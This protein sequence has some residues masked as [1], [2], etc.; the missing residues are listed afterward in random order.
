MYHPL[1][2]NLIERVTTTTGGGE[3][4][5]PSR[6]TDET[7]SAGRPQFLA[8]VSTGDFDPSVGNADGNPEIFLWELLTGKFHQLTNTAAPVVNSDPYPSDSGR[9][10][11]FSSSGDL[12]NNDGSDSGNPGMGLSNP[13][14][15]QEVF[16]YSINTSQ[17]FPFDGDF[18]QVSNGPA[19]TVSAKPVIGGYWFPRQCQSTAYTSDFDQLGNG[20]TGTHIYVYNRPGG[21][22]EQMDAPEIP[23]GLSPGNYFD[24]NISS[25]SNFARGPFVVFDTDSDLWMNQS[26]GRNLFRFRVFHPRMTQ[27]TDQDAGDVRAP[28]TSDGGKWIALESEVSYSTPPR[29]SS[30]G[31][32]RRSTRTATGKSFV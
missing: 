13:D 1:A 11:V 25:A 20:A 26:T 22:L 32:R 3:S 21:R 14:G 8:F 30:T 27:Y 24:P 10:I 4:Y 12:D 5:A 16:I 7:F 18:T 6:A 23:G 19:G 15:S 9:C 28:V 31:E 17:N 29:R 2:P